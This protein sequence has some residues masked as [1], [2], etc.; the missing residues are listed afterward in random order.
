MTDGGKP[1]EPKGSLRDLLS[2]E[3]F[4]E[5]LAPFPGDGGGPDEMVLVLSGNPD[6]AERINAYLL[7]RGARSQPVTDRFTALD[8][9]RAHEFRAF[10]IALEAIG[11]EPSR[12]LERVREARSPLSLGFVAEADASVPAW[13]E[14]EG[15]LVRRP[16]ED[17]ELVR[18]FPWAVLSDVGEVDPSGSPALE[19]P[20]AITAAPPAGLVPGSPST[21][22]PAPAGRSPD[23]LAAVRALLEARRTG[24]ATAEALRRWAERD[25]ACAG[26]GEVREQGD[27]LNLRAG[28]IERAALLASLA[29]EIDAMPEPPQFPGTRGGFGCLPGVPAWT[30][31]WWRDPDAGRRG[32]ERLASLLPLVEAMHPVAARSVP[33][34]N[35]PRERLLRLLDS[36]M[37]ASTRHGG[38]LAL[39]LVEPPEPAGLLPLVD[40]IGSQMR[41]E[42]WLELTPGRLWILLDRPDAAVVPAITARLRALPDGGR[43]RG[44]GALWRPGG[45]NAVDLVTRVERELEARA[46]GEVQF[47]D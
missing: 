10:I 31:F 6:D 12:Y 4:R 35:V 21:R 23:W 16:L 11:P 3:E 14:E 46:P 34:G 26:W 1:F 29:A 25:P 17:D 43:L 45:E 15:P 2:D 7:R 37:H 38:S 44:L 41:G 40:A 13:I 9:L 18:L 32:W 28:G 36:R 39:L 8:E 19:P 47:I 33:E 22:S 27:A 30:A 5:I 24:E 42:D 20:H